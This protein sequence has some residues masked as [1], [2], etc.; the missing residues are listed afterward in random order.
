MKRLILAAALAG[1]ASAAIVPPAHAYDRWNNSGFSL[2]HQYHSRYDNMFRYYGGSR[3]VNNY[4]RPASGGQQPPTATRDQGADAEQD[5]KDRKWEAF[6]AP[7]KTTDNVGI[8]TLHYA[9]EGCEFGR[10]Q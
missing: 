6:C 7:T 1:L 5:A 2:D 8:V 4:G 10:D 9:H 3:T